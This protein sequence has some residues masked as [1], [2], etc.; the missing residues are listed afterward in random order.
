M[1]EWH[2]DAPGF[3]RFLLADPDWDD[4]VEF[5]RHKDPPR[6]VDLG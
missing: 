3:V 5:P 1:T 6:E 2:E 4:D